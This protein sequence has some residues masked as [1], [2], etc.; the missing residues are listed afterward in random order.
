MKKRNIFL[1]SSEK[2]WKYI[3]LGYCGCLSRAEPIYHDTLT[4]GEGCSLGES[5]TE[6]DPRFTY[7]LCAHGH[8]RLLM[9]TCIDP[10]GLTGV[11]PDLYGMCK[12]TITVS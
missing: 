10:S 7:Q 9:P 8:T 11:E 4:P 12:Y 3:A 2:L 1:Q 5:S 6:T